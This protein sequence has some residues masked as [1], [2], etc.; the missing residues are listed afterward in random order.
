M[1]PMSTFIEDGSGFRGSFQYIP[2]IS[3]LFSHRLAEASMR[4]LP[5][6]L[7]QSAAK[8]RGTEEQQCL[9]LG[10]VRAGSVWRITIIRYYIPIYIYINILY[11]IINQLLQ[12]ITVTI[13]NPTA[14]QTKSIFCIFFEVF[15]EKF[16]SMPIQ[17]AQG[18]PIQSLRL[19]RAWRHCSSAV[20]C[21]VARG[22]AGRHWSGPGG[23]Y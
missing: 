17:S 8:S 20:K 1:D 13:I 2:V 19:L 22:L 23:R 9:F 18:L 4:R 14:S 11:S 15:D 5:A 3:S 21:I 6:A 10:R 7:S 12:I 16:E